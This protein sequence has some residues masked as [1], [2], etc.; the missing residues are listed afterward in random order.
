MWWSRH[1]LPAL[2][3]ALAACGFQPVYGPGGTGTRLQN[4]V[5][6]SE[7]DDADS[8]V[9]TRQ[10]EQRLGRGAP[11][12][13]TL[14]YTLATREEGLAV[15]RQGYTTRFNLLG[16]AD[17]TLT[18]IATGR[19]VTSGSVDSFTGYSATGTTVATLASER[20]ARIRL[21]TILADE[22][23]QR[24]LSSDLG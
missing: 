15:D 9:V 3:L 17:Y 7:P 24:L 13:Y 6:V 14:E 8:Y 2:L 11:A 1:L 19:V 18:E 20:D 5:L 12:A 21:M 22:I 23:V 16:K 4:Q 10:L